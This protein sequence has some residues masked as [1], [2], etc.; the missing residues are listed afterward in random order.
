MPATPGRS[1]VNSAIESGVMGLAL[2]LAASAA[3]AQYARAQANYRSEQLDVRV[4]LLDRETGVAAA[5]ATLTQGACSASLAGI[6][7]LRRR[8]LELTPYV[9]QPDGESCRLV[10]S[11]DEKW[12][13]VSA[14]THG[15]CAPYGGAACEWSGQSA[16]RTGD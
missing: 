15:N 2:L 6:G 3:Q 8:T 11:F 10:L 9:K 12:S 16:A 5:S 13:R 4:V 14:A 1:R 7:Q